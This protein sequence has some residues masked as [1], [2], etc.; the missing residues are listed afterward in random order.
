MSFI[1]STRQNL[2]P[3]TNLEHRA[4][5]TIYTDISRV[6]FLATV[7]LRFKGKLNCKHASKTT[8]TP[9]QEAPYNLASRIRLGLNNST[10]I[11][12]TSGY[13]AYLQ[14]LICRMN[15]MMDKA[16]SGCFK[17][18][19]KVSAAGTDNDI[20]FTLKVNVSLND[21]DLIGLLLLQSSQ[22]VAT[23]SIDCAGAGVLMQDT[24]ITATL[25]GNWYLSYEYFDVPANAGE[26]PSINV[27]H[28]VL[29]ENFA[30]HATGENT[31]TIPRGN[32]FLRLIND[33]QLNG[34]HTLD[35]VEKLALKYNKANEPYAMLKDD[36][37]ATQVDRY[38]RALPAG[39]LV[40]DF[41]YSFGVPNLGNQR[42]WIYT[43][44]ISE[45]DQQISIASGTTLGS[46]NNSL[47]MIKDTLLEVST[48]A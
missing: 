48:T 19:N 16:E 41:F 7:L 4:N 5:N 32:I 13:G 23:V 11:W 44:K 22:I 45:F 2:R 14:N 38:G 40:W 8:F 27:V 28:Q 43:N 6:G 24:D 33:I 35:G 37:L 31:F 29:E 25:S 21:R 10:S 36:M 12:D 18:D 30:I 20:E 17:F 34:V 46:N 1:D 42:D 15:Y 3:L 47:R 39:A 9:A 26:Y